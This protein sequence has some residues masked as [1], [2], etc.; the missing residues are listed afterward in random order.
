M[1][2]GMS[3]GSDFSLPTSQSVREKDIGDL[4]LVAAHAD[5][6][7]FSFV[8]HPDDVV[9][10]QH[11]L[12]RL[13]PLGLSAPAGAGPVP[14]AR[15]RES[16]TALQSS[17]FSQRHSVAAIQSA[18][19]GPSCGAGLR[20]SQTKATMAKQATPLSQNMSVVASR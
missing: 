2:S 6:V 19:I 17:Q 8:Q 13:R 16:V 7:A 3:V 10:P 9:L 20:A 12:E 4:A 1:N 5:G 14:P 11:A 18:A 15:H